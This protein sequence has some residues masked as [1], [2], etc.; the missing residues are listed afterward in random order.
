MTF[1]LPLVL[2][3]I[4]HN[5]ISMALFGSVMFL[6]AGECIL[7]LRKPFRRGK[8]IAYMFFLT[9]LF[10]YAFWIPFRRGILF[11]REEE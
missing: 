5:D 3:M 9:M 8:S 4:G 7:T 1:L 11:R 6:H 10:G 2:L